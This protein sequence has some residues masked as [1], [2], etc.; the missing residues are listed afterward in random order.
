MLDCNSGFMAS[1]RLG[2]LRSEQI[3]TMIEDLPS[4][5][6]SSEESDGNDEE[7]NSIPDSASMNCLYQYHM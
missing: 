6:D 7:D 3:L 2:Q 4:D 1:F 5:D